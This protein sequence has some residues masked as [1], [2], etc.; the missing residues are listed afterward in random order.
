[1]ETMS[2]SD[3]TKAPSE[4][5]INSEKEKLKVV[6]GDRPNKRPAKMVEP[7]RETAGRMA[8]A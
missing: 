6:A 3:N 7:E 1:M 8:R 5:G 4:A 2:F